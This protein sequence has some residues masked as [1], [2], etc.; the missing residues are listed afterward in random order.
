MAFNGLKEYV[1]HLEEQGELVRIR[2][3]VSPDQEMTEI[4]DRVSKSPGGGKALLF[5]NNGTSFPV[6]INSFGS[7][8]RINL[9]LGH[10][11]LDEI[12]REIEELFK[13]LT[14]PAAGLLDKVKKIPTL[15]RIASWMPKRKGGR[16]ACQEVVMPI[17]DVNNLPVLK[18]WPADGGPFVTLPCVVTR[19]PET[20][21]RNVGMYR[22]QV[23]D[24]QTTG[25]HW[26]K[27]KTG[28]RHYELYKKMGKRMPVAVVLGGDPAY[29]YAATAP[30]PD[31]IDEY[32]LAGFLRKKKVTLVKCL[33]HDLEVPEDADFIIEGFVDPTEPLVWEGPFGDHTGFYSLADWY[34]KFHITCITHRREAIYPATIVGIP[35]QED[36]YIG[37]ATEKIFLAPMRL[38]MIP[39]LKDLYLPPAGVAHNLTLAG[40]EKRFAGQAQK[41]MHAMWGAGQMMFNKIMVVTD[42]SNPWQPDLEAFVKRTSERI[43]VCQDL[44]FSNGPM[45]VL[46]HSSAAFAFGSKMGLDATSRFP[47]ESEGRWT[48]PELVMAGTDLTGA[49]QAVSYVKGIQTALLDKGISVLI[50]AIEKGD[51]FEFAKWCNELRTIP[52]V[53]RVKIV[54]A[55]DAGLPLADL[56]SIV[57]YVTG[58]MDPKR[59]CRQ[60]LASDQQEANQIF[61]DGTAKSQRFDGFKRDWPNPVVSSAAV[62]ERIDA[63]WETLQLGPWLPSPSRS[64]LPLKKGDGAI[65]E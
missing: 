35:P 45:D 41:T 40:I 46:D 42:A 47:E 13:D 64:Y 43:D 6:L 50:L 39:E 44:I 1:A 17:P 22:M 48:G 11:S 16:G 29:T 53:R 59:D 7:E 3:Q 54:V 60:V 28:A 18:C 61:M 55:V 21:I 9:A 65:A 56:D 27:H 63:L 12:S 31:Q 34:P 4:T 58:N 32:M 5:E 26:H 10:Q 23:F 19:D 51:G 8:R 38:T 30:L 14:G 25:M 49:L 24:G 36:A 20:G 52:S 15:S 57:W 37:L 62:I 2:H 33:T